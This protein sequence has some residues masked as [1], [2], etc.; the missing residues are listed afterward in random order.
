MSG[1]MKQTH[2][3][4]SDSNVEAYGEE[5]GESEID[6]DE[7]YQMVYG[8]DGDYSN[9]CL[10]CLRKVWNCKKQ[11]CRNRYKAMAEFERR[12]EKKWRGRPR[13]KKRKR[14]KK[15]SDMK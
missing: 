9:H 3:Y 10:F 5:E 2:I 14:E 15:K 6:E 4:D 7:Q 11:E 1:K 13:K 12:Q 8:V